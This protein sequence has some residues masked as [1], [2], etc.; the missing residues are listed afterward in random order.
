M[1]NLKRFRKYIIVTIIGVVFN[2]FVCWIKGFSFD[3]DQNRMF[4][5]LSDATFFTSVIFVGL[6][7]M[8]SISNFGLFTAVSYSLKRFFAI[9]S[10]EPEQKRKNMPS[11]YEYRKLKLE[12]NVS[13]AFIYIPGILFFLISMMFTLAFY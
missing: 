4:K 11:Y 7:S 3:M 1:D 12:D 2:I 5:L 6:G 8:I 13:G 9:F 10:R